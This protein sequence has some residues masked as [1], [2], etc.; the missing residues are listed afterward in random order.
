MHGTIISLRDLFPAIGRPFVSAMVAIAVTYLAQSLYG[1]AV[2]P[3]LR[4]I[5][6]G[7]ILTLVYL[8]ILI[9]VMGQKE[10]YLDLLRGFKED[11]LTKVTG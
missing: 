3:L 8:W 4:L 10:L 9:W 11:F 5:L 2:A 1:P 6:G 7:A